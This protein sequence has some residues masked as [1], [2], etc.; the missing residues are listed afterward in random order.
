M[1]KHSFAD[2]SG[3]ISFQW[4]VVNATALLTKNGMYCL[5]KFEKQ[6]ASS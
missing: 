6:V 5:I 1:K 3:S 4:S 2:I